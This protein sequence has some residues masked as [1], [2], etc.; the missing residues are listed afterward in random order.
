MAITTSIGVG[1]GIDISGVV[2]QLTAAEGKPQLDAIALKTTADQTKLSGLGTLKSALS[3]FQTA[4]N[5]LSNKTA[6]NTQKVSSTDEKILKVD[7]V[8][9]VLASS[10]S[11]KVE[12]LAKAQ[13]SIATTGFKST[14]NVATG[15][16]TFKDAS[17]NDAFSVTIA[18][19][20]DKLTD[21]RDIINNSKDNT[22]VTASII[23]VDSNSGESVSKLLL[24]AKVA[25]T[26]GAFTINASEGD[27]RFNLDPQNTPE[28][29]INN[30]AVNA[31][32]SLDPQSLPATAQRSISANEFLPADTLKSG[33]IFFK[34][35][36]GNERFSI[37]VTDTQNNNLNELK[38]AIN[39]AKDNDLVSADVIMTPSSLASIDLDTG[40]TVNVSSK[41]VLTAK[42]AGVSN[43]FSVDATQADTRLDFNTNVSNA[44]KSTIATPFLGSD[45]IA[46]G[47]INFR[48][49]QG[50]EKFSILIREGENDRLDSFANAINSTVGN[51]LV[52]ASVIT[53]VNEEDGSS[54]S[55]L[56]LTGLKGGDEGKFFIDTTT[57]NGDPRFT[58]DDINSSVNFFTTQAT[59]NFNTTAAQDESDNG[60]S[61]TR[62]SN[63]ID[64]AIPGVTLNLSSTGTVDLQAN[65]DNESATKL[66]NDFVTAYNAFNSS[67]N[68]LGKFVAPGD[69]GNGALVG[70][71][72]IQTLKS[73]IRESIS[74]VVSTSTGEFNSLSKIGISFDKSGNLTIDS[75]K[76]KT[77]LSKNV[78]S[79]ASI[80]ISS[81]GVTSRLNSKIT[82]Y[83]QTKGVI[84][85]RQDVLNKDLAALTDQKA[86]VNERLS[87]LQKSLNKQ[88]TAMDSA[89]AQ[90][91]STGDF[92]TQQ[93]N[94]ANNNNN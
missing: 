9:D 66:V 70:D 27:A 82:P 19:G 94:S 1:S 12:S 52:K 15:N 5:T 88:F 81:D 65:T 23:N 32:I 37:E 49:A 47:G 68:S 58:L 62:T 63:T 67:V 56:V 34:D 91:K 25:G 71:S 80:F 59:A 6:F 90:F 78:T 24:T 61:L 69:A 16:L 40:E 57:D 75:D 36:L 84:S 33:T 7:A 10:H 14:D 46:P 22:L 21:L 18:S 2:S 17:G 44:Q 42:K 79:V 35:T 50:N 45:V 92:L 74:D 43:G 28:N 64:D 41:L 89:V 51:N 26:K 20:K 3:A 39:N 53:T 29:F 72:I 87:S 31:K 85:N 11:I 93:L 13:K 60:Q 76:F 4:V 77:S 38:D 83:L 55:T 48:D 73:Q 8:N 54:S 30:E 86:K